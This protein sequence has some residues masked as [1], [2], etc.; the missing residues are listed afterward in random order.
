[1]RPATLAEVAERLRR[2]E[3]NAAT[4][5]EFLDDFYSAKD[6]DEAFAMLA[7]EPAI[8][9][10][11]I[12][13]ALLAAIADYLAVQYVGRGAPRWTSHTDRI[14]AEPHFTTSS[15]AP[16][17]KAWLAHNSPAEFKRHNI[18]T[19][20]RPLRRKLSERVAWAPRAPTRETASRAV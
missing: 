10:N 5:A 6:R 12:H 20:P 13:D 9:E 11:A 1:M 19:E 15:D 8:G 18:F 14:L 17:M 3:T 16:E 7:E 2:G 4:L